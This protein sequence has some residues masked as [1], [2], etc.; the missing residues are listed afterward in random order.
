MVLK[1]S[2]LTDE[3]I[4]ELERS[5]REVIIDLNTKNVFYN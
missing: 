3:Q 5:E 2:K 4:E 1:R